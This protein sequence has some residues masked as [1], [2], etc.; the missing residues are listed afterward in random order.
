MHRPSIVFVSLSQA[1]PEGKH[2]NVACSIYP[3]WSVGNI[4]SS[5]RY[6]YLSI[7]PDDNADIFSASLLILNCDFSS[8]I[9]SSIAVIRFYIL[10]ERFVLKREGLSDTKVASIAKKEYDL[11]VHVL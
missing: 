1:F 7:F 9:L 5:V 4:S 6:S 10:Q 3:L 2:V 11:A 8:L